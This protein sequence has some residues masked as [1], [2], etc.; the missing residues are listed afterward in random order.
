M[1]WP[2][3]FYFIFANSFYTLYLSYPLNIWS[4]ISLFATVLTYIYVSSRF[5]TMCVDNTNAVMLNLFV[6][7]VFYLKEKLLRP[8]IY[9]VSYSYIAFAHIYSN[10]IIRKYFFFY[11]HDVQLTFVFRYHECH[12]LCFNRQWKKYS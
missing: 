8:I 11:K 1:C 3:F 10:V 4:I 6:R 5:S 12:R 7:R 2:Y 9:T